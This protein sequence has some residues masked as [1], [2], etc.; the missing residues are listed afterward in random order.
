MGTENAFT[1]L[2]L[3]PDATD[4][5]VKAAWRR[6]VSQ[7]HPDRN[8]SSD[9]VAKMQRI[10]QAFEE[11]RRAGTRVRT[12]D[13]AA[14]GAAP[15][16]AQENARGFDDDGTASRHAD[17][18]HR[19]RRPISRKVKLTLEEAAIGCIKVLRGKVTDVCSTCAGAGH[20]V[21]GGNCAQCGGSGA[22]PKRSF[23]GWPSGYY[24]CDACLGGGIARQPCPACD[25]SGKMDARAYKI[26]VRIPHGVRHGDLLHVAGGRSRPDS[27]P[28]DLEIRVEVSE[29]AFF[30]LDGDGTIRCEIPVDGF[31]W[32]ANRSIQVPTVTGLHA[33]QL[34]REQLS[35]RLKGQGFP[36]TRRGA[37]GDQVITL[38]P[39]FPD[40]LSTDQQILL[41]QLLA[42][43][44]GGGHSPDSRLRAW[45][46]DLRAWERGLSGR[47]ATGA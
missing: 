24:E 11:I 26:K 42:T 33:L 32:I 27:P 37:R 31:A 45:S 19:S 22:M 12:D 46:R 7:W 6:L 4:S 28:A 15:G 2:G 39:I 20:Q 8:D 44:S 16:T 34:D 13:A 43:T 29:H 41:D 18:A 17:G 47:G 38:S 1:E 21:L 25:G 5:E 3:A 35:Y 9:A 10:N 23:F 14:D 40:S 30:Q 36:T